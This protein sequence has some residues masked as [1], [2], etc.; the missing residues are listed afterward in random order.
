MVNPTPEN[1]NDPPFWKV[2]SLDE[3]TMPEWES[4]CDGCARCCLNKL[5]DED[6][7]EIAWTDIACLLLDGESCRC[8]DYPNRQK[9]VPDCIPLDPET[10][11]S[12]SWLP[13]TCGY[14]LID[15]GRELYWWHPLVSGDPDTVHAAGVSVRG[16]TVREE[17][18]PLEHWEERLVDWP[19]KVP[20]A[21]RRNAKKADPVE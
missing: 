16:R 15:E 5:E 12:L 20:K 9:T 2:K 14:R 19:L 8:R 1:E 10:V 4:L 21:A 18:W 17:D 3:M 6:T 13:P 11:R 7:G